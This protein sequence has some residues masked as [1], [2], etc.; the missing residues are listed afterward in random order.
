LQRHPQFF[1]YAA[2]LAVCFF[3][4]TTYLTIRM[5]LET[6][7]PMMLVSLRYTLAGGIMLI[8]LVALLAAFIPARRAASV[9]PVQAL[10]A[11]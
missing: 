8:G 9:N 4:G 10:R 7:P 6:W 1:A 2:L 11:E 5:G 3:W